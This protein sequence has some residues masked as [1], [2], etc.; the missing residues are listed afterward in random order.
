VVVSAG[1]FTSL[2]T[3]EWGDAARWPARA[4]AVF[5]AA[6]L[7]TGTYSYALGLAAA[8]AALRFLQ[9]G[10]TALALACAALALGFSPL[11]FA[12]LCLALAAALLVR[13]RFGRQAVLVGGTVAVLAGGQIAVVALFPTESRYPYSPVS[14][15]AVLA[16]SGLG[17]AL[18]QRARASLLAAFLALWGLTNLVAFVVP[19]PFGD[20]LT[21]LRVFAFPLVLLAALLAH[22]RPRWLAAAALGVA[23]VYNVGPDL[24][25]LPKR[26][27]DARTAEQAFWEPALAFLRA[28]GSPDYRVEVVP[29]F[30]HWEAYWVPRAG[31]ALA[32]G[33]YRQIDVAEN[34]ELYRERLTATA[35]RG[36]LR[37]LG[38]RFV[39]LPA[40]RLGP[41]GATREADLLRSGRSGLRPVLRTRAWTIFELP[42]AV[43]ILTGPSPARVDRLDHERIG[44]WVARPG[45]FR[46]RVRYT[47][48]WHVV[49]GD[50][51]VTRAS[52]GMTALTAR[53]GGRFSLRPALVG[54]H[55]SCASDP[56]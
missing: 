7:F 46:L 23:V 6:P 44:G 53:R 50:V 15:L 11:A 38:V 2:A 36:W 40:A 31:A 47:P 56:V 27:A 33:W 22:F 12:F 35:Y 19:S 14:L 25:A 43:P 32:R 21:R 42:G 49:A 51:C 8:L 20:N 10:R 39:L 30:G 55:A 9:V 34:P 37:R 41:L 28:R 52:D 18:A 5:A 48:Y 13:R 4:F 16:V 17:A 3:H 26:A 45:V 1:V 54:S 29:T 24:S